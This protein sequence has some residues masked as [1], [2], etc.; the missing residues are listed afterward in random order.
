MP[1]PFVVATIALLAG[2]TCSPILCAQTAAPTKP[3]A[4][5][6][7]KW[8]NDPFDGTSKVGGGVANG[9]VAGDPVGAEHARKNVAPAPR[10]DLSGI[11]DATGGG[12]VQANGA[13]EHPAS[14]AA[15]DRRP[16]SGEPD[17][18]GIINPIP[19][20]PFGEAALEANKP[21]GTSIRSVPS[22]LGNDPGNICDPVGFPYM[23]NFQF[24]TIELTQ[25]KNHVLYLGEFEHRWRIIWTD[26]RELPKD[27]E[28]RWN[29]YSVGHWQDD[30]TF[31]AETVGMDERTWLDHAGRPHTKDLRVTEI[32][33]LVDRDTMEHTEIITDPKMYTEP[34]KA[35]D[36]LILRRQRP[37][38]DIREMFCSPSET[39]EYNKIVGEHIKDSPAQKPGNTSPENK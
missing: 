5:N 15:G 35:H 20:T 16:R 18:R 36:K 26:G 39:A 34:W 30:Y 4:A 38:F 23:E 9:K 22:V 21:T 37:D 17:E 29:G 6:R 7:E 28:P 3:G 19:Y 10:R 24:L 8:N 31:V 12:G 27:P 33:H 13:A 2:L 14:Y 32:Y 25:T 11:W 1:K